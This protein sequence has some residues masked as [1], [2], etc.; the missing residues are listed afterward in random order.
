VFGEV[1]EGMDVVKAVE[2]IGTDIGVP[3]Q[4]VMITS[5]GV[6]S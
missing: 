1:V 4:K 3:K 5:S 6:V 2:A